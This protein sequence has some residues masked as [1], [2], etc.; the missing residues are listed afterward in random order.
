MNG[1]ANPNAT[2]PDG[3]RR[4]LRVGED[5]LVTFAL[6]ALVILPL[7]EIVLRR[8]F[9]SGISGA[10]AIQQHLTLV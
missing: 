7:L 6:G 8:L 3:W 9:H 2:V 10:T 1:T 4:W 5:S